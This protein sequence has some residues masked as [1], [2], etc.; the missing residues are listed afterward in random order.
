VSP[1]VVASAALTTQAA[2][3]PATV[4]LGADDGYVYALDEGAGTLRW[5]HQLGGPSRVLAVGSSVVYAYDDGQ[6]LYALQASDGAQLWQHAL[7]SAY[8]PAMTGDAIYLPSDGQIYALG[9]TSG[10]L[11]WAAPGSRSVSAAGGVVYTTTGAL[12]NV[13]VAYNAADGS[14]L[15][16]Y[17]G[18]TAPLAGP[19]PAPVVSNGVAYLAT[20]DSVLALGA[21]TGALLWETPTGFYNSQPAVTA[22]AVYIASQDGA[23][24]LDPR[25]GALLWSYSAPYG[26]D[27]GQNSPLVVDGT[28][29]VTA[30]NVLHAVRASDGCQRWAYHDDGDLLG[31]SAAGGGLIFVSSRGHR[32][33]A[34]SATTGQ[35]AWQWPY[36]APPGDLFL[37]VS[38]ETL[39][40]VGADLDHTGPGLAYAFDAT[41]GTSLWQYHT[42]GATDSPMIVA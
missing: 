2:P 14:V 34:L 24:A 21:A 8:T 19:L 32:L 15:W 13:V 4:Y 29:Y 28:L 17:T 37:Q 35:I 31:M 6:M 23:E 38:G 11:L 30:T 36:S 27:D 26:L 25:T 1:P 12:S 39:V 22:T 41:T 10:L 16:T 40:A 9:A 20:R 33:V 5:R 18:G 7:D 3:P 42:D